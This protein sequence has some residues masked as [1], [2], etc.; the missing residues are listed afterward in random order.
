MVAARL[1]RLELSDQEQAALN[2][3]VRAGTSEARMVERARIVLRCSGDHSLVQVAELEG[4]SLPTVKKWRHRYAESG[5]EGLMDA[6]RS[7]RPAVYSCEDVQAVV[8]RTLWD[9]PADGA[10]RWSTRSMAREVGMAPS[11]VA[12]IW[13]TY[14]LAPHRIEN[15][16]FS[17]DPDFVAKVEDVVG[18]Y[19]NPPEQ[20]LV[21][22]L[23]EKS[24]IQALN[25]TQPALPMM[26]GVPAR[27]THDYVRHGTSTL[28]AAY[29]V[30]SGS[31]LHKQSDRHRASEFLDF[32][33]QID[34]QIPPELDLHIVLDNYATHKTADVKEWLDKHPRFHFHFIP[35][36]S[37]WLNL[38]ERWFGD[39]TT[40][41]LQGSTHTS[42]TALR[43]DITAWI[44][45]WNADPRPFAWIKTATE[46][47]QRI[48]R[49]RDRVTTHNQ[50]ETN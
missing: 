26:A 34:R 39:L 2:S 15:F 29:D 22:C 35:T 9:K 18:L 10:Q 3:I 17:T 44:I 7:G 30:A 5:L 41:K 40:R 12:H 13:K 8:Y 14:R 1:A 4:V 21:L 28:F 33:K 32:L 6:P 37:S 31:V 19:L 20:A 23:D 49:Y 45:T 11:K 46:I 48:D 16:K 42:V 38:V 24:Q 43:K 50:Q 27:Q 47:F 25:R 36:S